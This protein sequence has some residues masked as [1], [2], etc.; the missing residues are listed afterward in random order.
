MKVGIA[1]AAI[2]AALVILAAFLS[3]SPQVEFS[4][5]ACMFDVIPEEKVEWNSTSK[6]LVA[7]VTLTGCDIQLT[8]RKEGNTYVISESTG[9]RYCKCLCTK[10]LIIYNVSKNSKILLLENG[11]ERI[12]GET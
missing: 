7:Y 9:N 12:I 11:K 10:K 2:A 8:V 3:F 4:Q 1:I 5:S 6:T